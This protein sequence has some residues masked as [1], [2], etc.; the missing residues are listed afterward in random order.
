MSLHGTVAPRYNA[1]V[2][3]HEMEPCYKR[4]ALYIYSTRGATKAT[5]ANVRCA[6]CAVY[7]WFIKLIVI[8]NQRKCVLR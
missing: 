6:G 8:D 1:V 5:E 2:G 3:V 4:G 7:S